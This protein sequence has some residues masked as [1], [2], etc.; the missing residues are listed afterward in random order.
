MVFEKSK[1]PAV[2]KEFMVWKTNGMERGAWLPNN[3]R[4]LTVHAK[5]VHGND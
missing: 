1:A 2:R 5:L 3:Q 4:N